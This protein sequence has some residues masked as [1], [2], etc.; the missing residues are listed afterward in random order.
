LP[1]LFDYA[2]FPLPRSGIIGII[3]IRFCGNDV[4]R[5]RRAQERARR[6]IDKLN[7]EVNTSVADPRLKQPLKQFVEKRYCVTTDP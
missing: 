3:V 4:F 2:D 6:I 1:W 7:S 5:R